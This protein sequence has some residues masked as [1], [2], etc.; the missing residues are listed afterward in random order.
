MI[1][2]TESATKHFSQL[3]EDY[4]HEAFVFG[5]SGGGCAG[6][7]YLLKEISLDEVQED[8]EV[9]DFDGVKIVV[10][11]ASMFAIAGTQ[12]DWKTDLMGSRFDFSNPLAQSGCGCGTSFSI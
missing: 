6:F 11:G 4:G 7:N 8:D 1:T 9:L 10:D 12:I 2:L 3:M 5:V